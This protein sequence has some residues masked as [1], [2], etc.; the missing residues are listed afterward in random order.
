MKFCALCVVVTE[1]VLRTAHV[2]ED[3][4]DVP[5]AGTA[6]DGPEVGTG[7]VVAVD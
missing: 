3:E 7:T 5:F 2:A 4:Q 6:A 1:Q